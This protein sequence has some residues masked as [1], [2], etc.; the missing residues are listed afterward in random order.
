MGREKALLPIAGEVLLARIAR[1]ALGTG[2]PVMVIGRRRPEEWEL[3]Q[4]RFVDDAM[5]GAG[6]LGG[7][8][9]A[10]G[11]AGSAVIAVACDMPLMEARALAWLMGKYD[12]IGKEG[13]GVVTL[14]E[15]RMEPL[16]SL[17]ALGALP[18]LAA[19]LER[20]ELA[21]RAAIDAGD[22]RRIE[23]PPSIAGALLNVNTPEELAELERRFMAERPPSP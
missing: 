13:D 5:P 17:Y 20:S 23:V 14:R 16:F 6:P 11:A 12:Q 8:V 2:S 10:L 22:F 21:L 7:I 19:R 4:V 18:L 3:D 9:T 1:A 15:G